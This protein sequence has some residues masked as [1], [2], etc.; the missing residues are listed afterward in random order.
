M[1]QLQ[2]FA[3]NNR[4]I[5]MNLAKKSIKKALKISDNELEFKLL[6][7]VSHNIAKIEK[8]LINARS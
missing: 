7:D 1:K 4:Q 5:I 6:Y 8:H 3:W 2:N